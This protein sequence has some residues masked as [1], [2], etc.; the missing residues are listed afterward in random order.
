MT[1]SGKGGVLTLSNA[2]ELS[3]GGSISISGFGFDVRRGIYLLECALGASG[4]IPSPCAAISTT[5]WITNNPPPYAN[6]LPGV[7]PFGQGG[8]FT[9]AASVKVFIPKNDNPAEDINCLIVQCAIYARSDN[10]AGMDRS[11]DLNIP[12]TF[13]GATPTKAIVCM[14]TNAGGHQPAPLP[15]PIT[16]SNKQLSRFLLHTNCGDIA[17][18]TQ[19][20][21]APLTQTAL[22]F[23]A[24]NGFYDNSL[25]HRLTTNGIFVLQCGDPTATGSGSPVGW[26]GYADENLPSAIQN[27]YPEGTVAMANSGPNTNG[28]QFFL[29]YADTTLP[30]SYTIWGHVTS[31]L[32][33]LK[34]IASKGVQGGG[35]DGRPIA[36][37]I[38]SIE[39][40]YATP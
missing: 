8:I 40:M 30:P 21:K 13:T 7:A 36:V 12:I 15:Q 5:A 2:S 17:I 29:V 6:G 9:V 31:G 23:L 18:N 20:Q 3:D 28:S 25:C 32:D 33:I 16:I 34:F 1:V 26:R 22:A 35:S 11:F 10:S 14:P 38:N 27:N 19:D 39:L 24:S 4:E 37:S